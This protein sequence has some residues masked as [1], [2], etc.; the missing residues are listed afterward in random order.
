M[1]VSVVLF[2]CSLA[3]LVNPE[4]QMEKRLIPCP[5]SEMSGG[6]DNVSPH[7]DDDSSFGSDDVDMVDI[8]E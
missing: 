1:K 3:L 8:E 4:K 7:F 5:H 6:D 2:F